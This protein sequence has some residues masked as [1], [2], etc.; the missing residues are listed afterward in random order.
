MRYKVGE[1]LRRTLIILTKLYD[2]QDFAKPLKPNAEETNLKLIINDLLSKN[3]LPKN[4]KVESD[5]RKVVADCTF[6]NR[7]ITM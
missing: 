1:R 6:I 7:I 2:L 4:V 3:G 5:A